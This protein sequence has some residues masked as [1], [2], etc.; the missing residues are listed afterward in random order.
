MTKFSR[1]ASGNALKNEENLTQ[2][3]KLTSCQINRGQRNL[4]KITLIL[5][6]ILDN[7]IILHKIRVFVRGRF[8]VSQFVTASRLSYWPTSS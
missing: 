7:L 3:E 1:H 2:A 8:F 4:I 6:Y 5:L